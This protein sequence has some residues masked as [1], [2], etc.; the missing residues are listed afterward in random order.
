MSKLVKE[1]FTEF[2]QGNYQRARLI[3]QQAAEKYGQHLFQANL[4]LCN[5]RERTEGKIKELSEPTAQ[6]IRN[7]PIVKFDELIHLA[8]QSASQPYE[9]LFAP[10]DQ[11][12]AIVMGQVECGTKGYA[13]RSH[14]IA[15]ILHENGLETIN[16]L[17]PNITIGMTSPQAGVA[18][19]VNFDGIKYFRS[20]WPNFFVS[21][22]TS[23]Y[24]DTIVDI[25][26]A[27][28]REHR[29]AVVI[30]VG[31]CLTA[32]A[33]IVA[34]K[35]LCLPI[36]KEHL[37]YEQIFIDS[38]SELNCNKLDFLEK[39]NLENVC[40]SMADHSFY[41]YQYDK[42]CC[43]DLQDVVRKYSTKND[44]KDKKDKIIDILPK[45]KY[46]KKLVT[47]GGGLYY[48]ELDV[49]DHENGNAKGVVA[50]FKFIDRQ[51]KLYNQDLPGF[52]S[53]KAYPYFKYIDTSK[54]N[55]STKV[56]IFQIPDAIAR[57]DLDIV[58]F[59][60]STKIEL[61]K[62]KLEKIDIK[63][64]ARWLT[65][66]LI[67]LKC[68]KD[69]ES[70]VHKEGALSLRLALLENKY[71]RT[72]NANDRSHLNAAIQEMVE[73]DRTWIPEYTST[74]RRI[75]LADTGKL[76]VAHLHKTAYP[77]ENTGGAIRCL[78]TVVSQQRIGID[79]YIITPIGYPRS[80]GVLNVENFEI[81]EGVEHFRIGANT[82]GLKGLSLPERTRYSAFHIA[83]ILQSRGAKLIHAAS[84]VRG[85]ELALEGLA[86]KKLT[87]LP[88]LYEVRSFHEHTWTQV[89]D[90][91]MNLEKT[92]LRVI[93]ENFCMSQ[94]DFVTTISFS[95]KKI[96]IDRGVSPSK[97]EVIPNAI[98]EN[99][100]LGQD[101]KPAKIPNLQ[102]ADFVVGYISNMS[103]REGHKYLILAIKKL[104]DITGLDIRG[105]LVGNGPERESLKSLTSQIGLE[106]MISFPGEVDHSQI[107]AYYKA[108]DFFVIPRI[109]DYAADWVTPLKPYEAMALD[110]PIIVTDLPALREIVGE[111]EERGLVAKPADVD[112]LV[113]KLQCY[114]DDPALR[115]NKVDTAKSWVFAERTWGANARRYESI[116]RRLIA[117]TNITDKANHYA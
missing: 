48:L 103:L 40:H 49:I 104:R 84:G 70:Y 52:S 108:I 107:N 43:I 69:I 88:L 64:V 106:N 12:V 77:Y 18:Y 101:F 22:N 76:T 54:N 92:K 85:Y 114:I 21:T 9:S 25:Y 96:L 75:K 67:E 34:A 37:N 30:V 73:L 102:G 1:A 93:K 78:N 71:K 10:I 41:D 87:G 23:Q 97:I 98:D 7:A 29:P 99:K 110:R 24:L 42:D 91:V 4:A 95:M 11:R 32:L 46:S 56:L 61:R 62:T 86:V 74:D 79:P 113:E 35:K 51:N 38:S 116:Y 17:S 115:Q 81:I 117:Q 16:I 83:K 50:S 15:K 2:K 20:N 55:E 13:G 63:D 31:D 44:K 19:H 80:V 3:Y 111:N 27:H 33:A 57:I 105:L 82:D 53:S 112:S 90:D 109:P 45:N 72:K 28:F 6:P 47:N 68:I 14:R 59:V 8:K 65:L 58:A 36:V 94:A 39:T 100:Y 66:N 60:T 5:R 89:R 26:T